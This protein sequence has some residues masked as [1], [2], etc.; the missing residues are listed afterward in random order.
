MKKLLIF[1]LTLILLLTSAACKNNNGKTK[2]E[3]NEV[4]H[5]IFYTPFYVAIEGGFFE[6]EGLEIS[7]TNGGG[8]DASMT[9]L[10]SGSCD[11]ALL[12]PETIIYTAIGG[13]KDTPKIFAQLT[14][15]DGSFLMGR[16][17][18]KNFTWQSLNGK[19]IIAGRRGGSP[20]MSLEYALNKN[21]LKD[22]ENVTL[23]YDVQFNLTAAAF[24]AG[25]GDYVTMF[26]PTA[27]EY[28]REGK[29][30]IV[31]SV[32]KESGEV[33]FTT[34]ATKESFIKNNEDL[35]KKF[36]TALYDAIK[37]IKETDT[38]KVAKL[39][40]KS[41]PSTSLQSII[42]SLNSYKEIDAWQEDLLLKKE[43]FN[44]LQEVM[45]NAGE[46]TTR[47]NYEDLVYNEITEDV[48]KKI[49]E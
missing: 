26:E 3:V 10:L 27:S 44:H 9:A 15:R 40:E 8:S 35:I 45:E 38:Q 49:F 39:L 41:F 12:G 32:G 11:I 13:A 16:K 14:K 1:Y 33:P 2:V 24:V 5:S 21:G 30:Y 20:A 7:L 42:D 23:N 48:Y 43:A 18:D 25:T 28:Q 47:V 34:F 46:L 19:E 29:A 4:T 36:T 31:A 17:E 22:G 6:K 37:Y